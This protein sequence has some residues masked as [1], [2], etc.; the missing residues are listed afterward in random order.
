MDSTTFKEQLKQ[1]YPYRIELH[2]LKA[3]PQMGQLTVTAVRN[4]AVELSVSHAVEV[5]LGGGMTN[6][7]D[8]CH[9]IVTLSRFLSFLSLYM[10]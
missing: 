9:K 1:R 6:Q 5:A 10:K 3:F 7:I 2:A 8:P 4:G